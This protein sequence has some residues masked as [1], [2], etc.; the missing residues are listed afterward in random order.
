MYQ[1]AA[2]AGACGV[3]GWQMGR[4]SWRVNPQPYPI[5]QACACGKGPAGVSRQGP[6]FPHPLNPQHPKLAPGAAGRPADVHAH[7]APCRPVATTHIITALLA[8]AEG[9]DKAPASSPA[10][11][12]R[13]GLGLRW[14]RPASAAA[15]VPMDRPTPPGMSGPGA[16][17]SIEEGGGRPRGAGLPPPLRPPAAAAA[18]AAAAACATWGMGANAGAGASSG[19]V[20]VR[21]DSSAPPPPPAPVLPC[22][23][24]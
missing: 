8:A 11:S 19:T 4:V 13:V 1:A 10:P 24:C 6:F 5:P 22:E 23:D 17:A 21:G 12:S 15:N 16:M 14:L 9:R 18:A 20:S 3:S 2:A 7:L